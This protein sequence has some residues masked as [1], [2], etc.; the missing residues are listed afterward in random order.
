MSSRYCFVCFLQI[1]IMRVYNWIGPV[2]TF[3]LGYSHRFL[4]P[5]ELVTWHSYV[6]VK[7]GLKFTSLDS[8]P[9][10]ICTYHFL[11]ILFSLGWGEEFCKN[12]IL[13]GPDPLVF[14]RENEWQVKSR[15]YDEVKETSER[16]FLEDPRERP[17][18]TNKRLLIGCLLCASTMI[19]GGIKRWKSHMCSLQKPNTKNFGGRF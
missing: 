14:C 15:D 1:G 2:N 9:S 19:D 4:R 10:T 12:C 3:I 11:W 7:L 8:Q 17:S 5:E 6:I 13:Q 16:D 18:C